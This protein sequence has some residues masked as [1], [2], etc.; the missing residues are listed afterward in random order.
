MDT[1]LTERGLQR[2]CGFLAA[3]AILLTISVFPKGAS[4]QTKRT[5]TSFDLAEI[6]RDYDR[7]Q[8]SLRL[9]LIISTPEAGETYIAG[10]EASTG[11]FRVI[12][13]PFIE[14]FDSLRNKPSSVNPADVAARFESYQFALRNYPNCA[15]CKLGLRNFAHLLLNHS[16]LGKSSYGIPISSKP[17]ALR[18]SYV[19]TLRNLVDQFPIEQKGPFMQRANAVS[20][21]VDEPTVLISYYN[22]RTG[23][24]E[25][26]RVFWFRRSDTTTLQNLRTVNVSGREDI[27]NYLTKRM[28]VVPEVPQSLNEAD[29][30]IAMGRRGVQLTMS[31]QKEVRAQVE[32]AERQEKEQQAL[33]AVE[34]AIR[35][36]L[37]WVKSQ[38]GHYKCDDPDDEL[39]GTICREPK[40]E[41]CGNFDFVCNSSG[42][43]TNAIYVESKLP[44]LSLVPT[45]I[46]TLTEGRTDKL[47]GPQGKYCSCLDTEYGTSLSA[48]E[49]LVLT[50]DFSPYNHDALLSDFDL[51]DKA[52]WARTGK[53]AL[54]VGPSKSC[55][56]KFAQEVKGIGM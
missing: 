21:D 20:L 45:C 6:R 35:K 44:P 17:G 55:S 24:D 43:W 19:K 38:R 29:E 22:S 27:T 28:V 10:I 42:G 48:G 39:V 5:A 40:E 31:T 34:K 12:R 4:A 32:E 8:G 50:Y 1:P 49:K 53:P 18:L 15:I 26:P 11:E 54:Y 33:E 9:F 13:A 16:A 36:R 3:L 51:F 14:I 25:T 30:L 37:G 7:Q 23:D 56:G 41:G 46:A 2:H 52:V 47:E